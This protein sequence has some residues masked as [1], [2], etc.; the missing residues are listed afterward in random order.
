MRSFVSRFCQQRTTTTHCIYG[1]LCRRA[2]ASRADFV[3][4]FCPQI[5]SADFVSSA[6]PPPVHHPLYVGGPGARVRILLAYKRSALLGH[7]SDSRKV[8][9]SAIVPI[10][11][12][13]VVP[14][15]W[16]ISATQAEP[17]TDRPPPAHKAK[18]GRVPS[19]AKTAEWV[20][21]SKVKMPRMPV[22]ISTNR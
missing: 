8:N 18:P 16:L 1:I 20:H 11:T 10:G 21:A 15:A 5:S 14:P 12:A 22:H 9:P 6:P 13:C 17:P 4:R 3:S 2:R 7:R 19:A